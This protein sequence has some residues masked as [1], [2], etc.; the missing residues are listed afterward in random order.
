MAQEVLVRLL[1]DVGESRHEATG[2]VT[3]GVSGNTYDLDVCDKHGEEFDR[4]MAKWVSVGRRTTNGTGRARMR[5]TTQSNGKG[6]H[7]AVREWARTRGIDVAPKG[8]LP[9]SIV[10]QWEKDTGGLT[11]TR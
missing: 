10:E 4:A 3:L 9:R 11:V 2:T 6:V 7:T 8:N 5:R 1:C